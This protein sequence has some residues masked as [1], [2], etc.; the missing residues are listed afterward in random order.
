MSFEV[1]SIPMLFKTKKDFL[2]YMILRSLQYHKMHG[3]EMMKHVKDVTEG[4]WKPSHSMIYPLL[5]D[6]ENEG[7]I[8][9]SIEKKGELVR[10]VY[11]LTGKGEEY[12]QRHSKKIKNFLSCAIER[13]LKEELTDKE[14][15][16]IPVFPL[17]ILATRLG[18]DVLKEYPPEARIKLLELLKKK[19]SYVL[20]DIDDELKKLKPDI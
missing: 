17:F 10:K 4:Q 2:R 16:E 12:L 3:Y 18:R 6:L 9:S 7:Y 5:K 13:Y 14:K 8:I 1:S 20:K 11:K 19:L 15:R